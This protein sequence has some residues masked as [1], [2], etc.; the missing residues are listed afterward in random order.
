MYKRTFNSKA[1]LRIEQTYPK[2]SQYVYHLYEVFNDLVKKGTIPKV[3]N[4]KPDK[5]TNKIYSTIRFQTRNLE[6][7]NVY[8]D[9]FYKL[10][11]NGHYRKV[12]PQNIADIL[13]AK[14]LAHWIMDD[15]HITVF[16]QTVLNTNSFSYN[17]IVL[18]QDALLNNFQ[19]RT[20]TTEKRPG[21]Y[22]IHI[23]VRQKTI[24][25]DIVGKYIIDS[26]KYKVK[27]SN[28]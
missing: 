14:G 25:Y 11:D 15:G 12:V 7:L 10:N 19:L 5:R 6:C 8:F 24:L 4:R 3:Y 16:N 18:L 23:P 2:H 17:E 1:H 9:L 21:Q 22:L 26:I 27:S 13:T 20:R 28:Y